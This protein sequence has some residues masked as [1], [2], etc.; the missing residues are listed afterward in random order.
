MINGLMWRILKDLNLYAMIGNQ[1][2]VIVAAG[3]RI[4]SVYLLLILASPCLIFAGMTMSMSMSDHI[5][6]SLTC[7]TDPAISLITIPVHE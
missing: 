1:S 3:F 7:L 5:T 6:K 2:C 4:R